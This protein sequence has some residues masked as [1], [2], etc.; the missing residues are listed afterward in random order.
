V[1]EI[2]IQDMIHIFSAMLRKYIFWIENA[3]KICLVY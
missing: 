1:P 2:I 3:Y